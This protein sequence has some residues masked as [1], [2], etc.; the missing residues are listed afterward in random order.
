[1]HS[2][3]SPQ[4]SRLLEE[5]VAQ[6]RQHG[7]VLFVGSGI[8]ARAIPQ[9][10]AL[11][12]RLID[13]S[14]K[15]ASLADPR[16]DAFTTCLANWSQHNFDPCALASLA[17][18]LL[19]PKRFRLEIQDALYQSL[20]DVAHSLSNYCRKP[21]S[22]KRDR[23]RYEF[24]RATAQLCSLP[25]VRAVV[26][27]NYDTLLETAVLALGKKTPCSYYGATSS[28]SVPPAHNQSLLPVFHVHGLLSAPNSMLRDLNESAVLSYDEYFDKNADPLSWETSTPV[29]FLRNFCTLW[30]GASLRDWNMLRLLHAATSYG[31]TPPSYCLMCLDEIHSAQALPP[32]RPKPLPGRQTYE[33]K[34]SFLKRCATFY[35]Q[36]TQLA[37]RVPKFKH[38]ALRLQATLLEEAGAHLI[39]GGLTFPDLPATLANFITKNLRPPKHT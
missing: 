37:P 25:Q 14:L 23:G 31:E 18:S 36:S 33:P 29:H 39:L 28:L 6:A 13:R 32:P 17:K 27:F 35:D 10:G 8:N 7:L 22:H 15:E 1:M 12:H 30:L 19:G 34:R 26:T 21:S 38:L 9:W 20:P 4:N 16:F 11:L 5:L 24:L 3:T 2:E